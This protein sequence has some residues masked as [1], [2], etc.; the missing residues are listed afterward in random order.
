MPPVPEPT[1]EPVIS[2]FNMLCDRLS[3]VEET[4]TSILAHLR[5]EHM[6]K[7]FG[8]LD[9]RLL[10]LQSVPI[11]LCQR[12][13]DDD[14]NYSKGTPYAQACCV[15]LICDESCQDDEWYYSMCRRFFPEHADV[16]ITLNESDGLH[17]P[18]TCAEV[19]IAS[20]RGHRVV[21]YEVTHRAIQDVLD[22]DI[23]RDFVELTDLGAFILR[24]REDKRFVELRDYVRQAIKIYETVGH[25]KSCIKR[26]LVTPCSF[27]VANV[28]R[29]VQDWSCIDNEQERKL[30]IAK[31]LT[32]KYLWREV[33]AYLVEQRETNMRSY[34]PKIRDM[35]GRS[36]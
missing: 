4:T 20:E 30:Y 17:R 9:T 15:Q 29:D 23:F 8:W 13:D 16:I 22:T 35:L 6:C 19:G 33:F 27:A 2:T 26:L 12:L 18:I 25:G 21:W 34:V 32:K 11:Y 5:L 3:E 1:L 14:N 10:G 7:S 28:L 36:H 24:A 31:N